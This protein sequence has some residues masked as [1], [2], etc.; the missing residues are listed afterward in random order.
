MVTF[1]VIELLPSIISTA[2]RHKLTLFMKPLNTSILI[3]N[4]KVGDFFNTKLDLS[5]MNREIL[6]YLEIGVI[7]RIITIVH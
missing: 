2:I 6:N 1:G 3:L 4:P 7:H 5:T